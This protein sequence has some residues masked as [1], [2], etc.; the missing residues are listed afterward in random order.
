MTYDSRS[1][2]TI[3]QI[4][5]LLHLPIPRISSP[6]RPFHRDTTVRTPHIDW[7]GSSVCLWI[8][9]NIN[10]G[11]NTILNLRCEQ[12]DLKNRIIASLLSLIEQHILRIFGPSLLVAVVR[13][14]PLD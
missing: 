14:R 6:G 10:E 7:T 5:R 8:D 1:L 2:P 4:Q 12:V 13:Y 11:I 9:T 3:L